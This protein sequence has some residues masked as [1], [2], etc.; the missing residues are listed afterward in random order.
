MFASI[1]RTMSQAMSLLCL[2]LLAFNASA[3]EIQQKGTHLRIQ[4]DKSVE[5]EITIKGFGFG[6]VVVIVN[7]G[8]PKVF[9]FVDNISVKGSDLD[10]SLYVSQS[11]NIAGTLKVKS[12]AGQDNIRISGTF[13]KNLKLNL[14]D[15]DDFLWE[16]DGE[17]VVG[18]NYSIKCGK[19][20]DTVNIWDGMLVYGNMSIDSGP[21]P[22]SEH[23]NAPLE[24]TNGSKH[25]HKKLS[26][27]L[28]K[29]T[30]QWTELDHVTA[31]KLMIRGG[32]HYNEADLS[33][34]D[35]SFDKTSIKKVDMVHW[36]A[37]VVIEIF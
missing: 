37:F 14:G 3:A 6:A 31:A 15:G 5:D 27:K 26:I 24:L 10:D 19:G 36:P 23:V 12:G 4:F 22:G 21:G 28:S 34:F 20:D 13:N 30:P 25:V 1:K 32:K 29:N 7:A 11:V 16:Y 2:G 35:N 17:T 8:D 9:T 33:D 18:G